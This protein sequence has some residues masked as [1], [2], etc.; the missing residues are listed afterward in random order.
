[1]KNF[2]PTLNGLYRAV[3]SGEFDGLYKKYVV[4]KGDTLSQIAYLN[5]TTVDYLAKVNDIENPDLILVDQELFIPVVEEPEEVKVQT[6]EGKTVKYVMPT[7]NGK[8]RIVNSGDLDGLYHKYIVVKGDT[9]GRIARDNDTTVEFLAKVNDIENVNL[10][11]I[12]QELLIP[13]KEEPVEEEKEEEKK[14][15]ITINKKTIV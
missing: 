12:D 10:I 8:F 14:P 11:E 5:N 7:L 9:L 15:T 2:L 13:E 3:N 1:M 6:V 4:V